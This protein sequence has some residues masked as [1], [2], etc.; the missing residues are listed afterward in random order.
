MT[1]PKAPIYQ[2][3]NARPLANEIKEL[4]NIC[5]KVRDMV[6]VELWTELMIAIQ[7]VEDGATA[8]VEITSHGRTA[9]WAISKQKKAIACDQAIAIL[10]NIKSTKG[11]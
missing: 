4:R 10:R 1:R 5:E 6:P 11:W 9:G 7:D 3:R 2:N 8:S